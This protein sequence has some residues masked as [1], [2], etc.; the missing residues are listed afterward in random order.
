MLQKPAN[1]CRS[2]LLASAV[3]TASACFGQQT[4]HSAASGSKVY[5][6]Y[7]ALTDDASIG[8]FIQLNVP[9]FESMIETQIRPGRIGS[10]IKLTGADCTAEKLVTTIEALQVGAN[11]TLFVFYEGHGAYNGN[12]PTTDPTQGHFLALPDRILLRSELLECM[13]TKNPRLQVLL[14]DCCNVESFLIV[15]EKAVFEQLTLDVRGW[16]GL[17]DLL[18]SYRG[19]VDGTASSRG[20]FSWFSSDV[21]GWFTTSFLAKTYAV[22]GQH[23]L[24][25]KPTWEELA[26]ETEEFFQLQKQ[27]YA[28]QDPDL[29]R[30]AHMRPLAYRL[31]VVRE[32]VID[33]P[34]DTRKVNV[35]IQKI[36]E[37][38]SN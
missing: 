12:A 1:I 19:E 7:A 11:D 20:E 37:P 16:T 21:G 22:S 6:V 5:V 33:A 35:I 24:Q 2:V 26:Q 27:R 13:R 17:E 34:I 4:H 28:G 30:Q 36:V 15:P 25:W 23:S 31:D 8:R 29:D 38:Q 9:S 14:S 32:E 3:L 10:F 18:L